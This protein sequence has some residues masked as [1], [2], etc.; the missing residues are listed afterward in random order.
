ML[1][2][3][4]LGLARVGEGEMGT[5]T[6]EPI[7][8]ETWDPTG[9]DAGTAVAGLAPLVT[10]LA[11]YSSQQG[12]GG[13]EDANCREEAD[14]ATPPLGE[15]ASAAVGAVQA[16]TVTPRR[17]S[18]HSPLE[19]ASKALL[20]AWDARACG[21]DGIADTL[22]GHVAALRSA[23]AASASVGAAIDPSRPQKDTK[24]AQVLAMLRRNE[25]A[26][27]P[28]I[29]EAMGWAS[30]TVRGFLAGLAKKGVRSGSARLARTRRVPRAATRSIA[31]PM[32]PRNDRAAFFVPAAKRDPRPVLIR[33]SKS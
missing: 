18:R 14:N 27:G 7:A 31:S 2:A 16:S 3:T 25:G 8:A 6:P 22:N 21:D 33:V 17:G 12:Q 23:L 28:Q 29:A 20:D 19:Q 26:S 24:Q 11:A 15:T 30:H 10:D 1:R 5:P 9:A 32:R 4:A 13:P